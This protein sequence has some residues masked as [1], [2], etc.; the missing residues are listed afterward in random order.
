MSR[1]VPIRSLIAGVALL[2]GATANGLPRSHAAPPHRHQSA[3]T[4]LYSFG[5]NTSDGLSPSGALLPGDRGAF[6]GTTV[7]GGTL[8]LGSVFE[9][10]PSG[11]RYAESINFDFH[12]SDG[13]H[14][15]AGLTKTGSR[16]GVGTTR[17]GGVYGFG[18][19]FQM[20]RT[21]D[22]PSQRVLYN[23]RGAKDGAHPYAGIVVAPQGQFFGTT[24]SGGSNRCANG[25]GIVYRLTPT[26]SGYSENVVY[27]FRGGA[28]GANPYAPLLRDKTGAFYGTT[29]SGGTSNAGTVFKLTP[30]S[31]GYTESVLHSFAGGWMAPIR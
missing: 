24:A 14:P 6:F 30:S 12:G 25:C 9:L 31:R 19:V 23:F 26:P 5:A 15:Y 28:D 20:S 21:K 22:G 1:P 8:G 2:L 29:Y 7:N 10:R 18:T 4:I 27:R 16:S 13:A 3:E 11:S 17:D